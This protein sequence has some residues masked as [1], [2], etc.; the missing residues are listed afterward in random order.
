MPAAVAL[1]AYARCKAPSAATRSTGVLSVAFV[2][3]Y[4]SG[5]ALHDF[6]TEVPVA[7]FS[8]DSRRLV[9]AL[10]SDATL[11]VWDVVRLCKGR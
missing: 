1:R 3:D 7:A 5:K 6:G 11:L 4:A 10:A 9:T 8:P 2:F